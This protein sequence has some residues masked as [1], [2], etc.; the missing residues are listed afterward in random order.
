VLG[1]PDACV[2]EYKDLGADG[3]QVMEIVAIQISTLKASLE[4]TNS[5]YPPI[6]IQRF[7]ESTDC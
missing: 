6:T 2:R 3:F 4:V 5:Q 1:F 7:R